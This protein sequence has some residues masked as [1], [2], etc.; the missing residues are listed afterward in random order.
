ME[1]SKLLLRGDNVGAGLKHIFYTMIHPVNGF[2]Q[3][4]WE[5]KGSVIACCVILFV[6]FLTNVFD[7]VLTGFIFNTYNPDRIS[8]PSIFLISMGG[9]A[10]IY[11]SNWA[12]GSLQFS[13]GENRDIFITLCYTLVPYTF[14]KLVHILLTNFANLEVQAF[15]TALIVIGLL[16]SGMILIVGMYYIHQ[17]SFGGLL[18]NLLLTVIGVA[19]ILFLLLLGYS[20]VQQIIT[21]VV[22]IYNEIVFRL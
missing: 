10:I 19:I 5:K 14:F 7:Q 13:E 17:F 2:D 22:T 15:L 6:F 20:L 16:W 8:V 9:F 21:F 11:I 4:K 3:V 1:R 12:A 18:V